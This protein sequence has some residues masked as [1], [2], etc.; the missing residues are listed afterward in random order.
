MLNI[1]SPELFVNKMILL[2]LEPRKIQLFLCE[3]AIR[4]LSGE[5]QGLS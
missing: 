4:K 3:V 2:F 1:I 5:A